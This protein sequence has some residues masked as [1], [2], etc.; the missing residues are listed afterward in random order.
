MI[1]QCL[2]NKNKNATV[3]KK[4]KV[5]GTKQGLR[6]SGDFDNTQLHKYVLRGQNGS[7]NAPP[8]VAK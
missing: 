2:S 6:S 1:G 8:H 3:P 5:F 4:Q 7:Y